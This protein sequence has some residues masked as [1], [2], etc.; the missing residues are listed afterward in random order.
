MAMTMALMMMLT[1]LTKNEDDDV[2]ADVGCIGGISVALLCHC[3][4]QMPFL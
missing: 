3:Q 2:V 4:K 1:M